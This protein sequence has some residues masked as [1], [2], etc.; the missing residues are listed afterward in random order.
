MEKTAN[1]IILIA[2]LVTA[3]CWY[4]VR[5]T[6]HAVDWPVMIVSGVVT[7]FLALVFLINRQHHFSSHGCGIAGLIAWAAAASSFRTCV[8]A[9]GTPAAPGIII[10]AIMLASA[11]IAVVVVLVSLGSDWRQAQHKKK[12]LPVMPM[13]LDHPPLVSI[14]L[15]VYEEPAKLVIETLDAISRLHYPNFEIIVVDQGSREDCWQPVQ[16]HCRMLGEH[17]HF[18]HQPECRG[19]RAAALNLALQ[20]TDPEASIIAVVHADSRVDPQMLHD[21]VPQFQLDRVAIVHASQRFRDADQN[22]FKAICNTEYRDIFHAGLKV[23]DRH[24]MI[25][26]HGKISLVRR[27]WLETS[28][29]WDE[30]SVSEDAELDIRACE[31]DYEV[32][33]NPAAYA[34]GL[35]PDTF[36]A[37]RQQRFRWSIGAIDLVRRHSRQAGGQLLLALLPWLND[38]LIVA[39]VLATLTWSIML[40]LMPS[41]LSPPPLWVS[42][43]L[44]LPLLLKIALQIHHLRDEVQ[45]SISASAAAVLARLS[46]LHITALA[47]IA[48]F[49]PERDMLRTP[50]QAAAVNW[51]RSLRF[52]RDEILL[53][54][55]LLAGISGLIL[56]GPSL[57]MDMLAW[58]LLLGLQAL[59]YLATLLMALISGLP[60]PAHRLRTAAD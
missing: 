56:H 13:E 49:H 8:H 45:A 27:S 42:I 46:L 15:P 24:D 59:P 39:T 55:G 52:A 4:L 32:I 6:T 25:L 44:A 7:G 18:Y 37:Y 20:H 17:V 31:Q 23:R 9:I 29:G 47:L 33:Y 48:H 60:L 3:I 1:F 11:L 26:H 35:M 41:M 10:A 58:L 53:L 40:I 5:T 22:L 28:G 36:A 43:L 12:K 2:A 14:H 16:Q 34:S 30:A 57:D 38:S 51:Q 21:L 54:G 50:K 19:F